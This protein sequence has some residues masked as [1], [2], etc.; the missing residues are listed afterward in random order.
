M[1]KPGAAASG[2]YRPSTLGFLSSFVLRALS[3]FGRPS[4]VIRFCSS[5]LLAAL[6]IHANADTPTSEADKKQNKSSAGDELFSGSEIRKVRIEIPKDGLA[7]LRR[8]HWDRSGA[9]EERA[10]VPVTVKE[11]TTVYTNVALHLKG[12]EGSFRPVD[13]NPAMTLN[14][15]K[16]APGQRFHGLQKISLN[17]S[18]EDP[19]FLTEKICRELF[20]AAGVPVPRADYAEVELNGRRVGLY[21][22][23]E[24][25]NKQFLRRYFKNPNGNLYDSGFIRDINQKLEKNSGPDPQDQSDLK[26]LVAAAN[27]PD[28]TNRLARLEKVLDLDLFITSF[29]MQIMMW[30]WDGYVMNINN[31]RIY[32]DPDSDRLTMMPHGLDQ[33]FWEPTGHILPNRIR[34]MLARSVIQMPECRRRYQERLSQLLT[35][36]F[37]APTITNRVLQQA[38]RIRPVLIERNQHTAK[39]HMHLVAVLCERIAQRAS[40]IAQQLGGPGKAIK[41]DSTGAAR[42]SDWKPKTDYG[43][44]SFAEQAGT[45]HNRWL[46]ISAPN[47]SSVGSWRTK[48]FLEAGLYRLEGKVKTRGVVSDPG[49]PR[50]GVGLRTSNRRLTQKLSGDNDWTA[51]TYEFDLPERADVEFVCELRAAK[52]EAWFDAGSLRLIRK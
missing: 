3:F 15:D 28:L 18:A 33:M 19:T 22:L 39:D 44:P 17:N 4:L 20:A 9:H 1:T 47:G 49:D 36:V 12:A 42:L 32:H 51:V 13:Q 45:D 10:N 43:E 35:N 48:I 34:G 8:Y 25:W 30:N 37:N 41:F 31:Y 11:G 14:F 7:K 2:R 5:S 52:G 24:G 29:A 38:A 23:V 40:S 16:F 50:F 46:H 6:V 21:V 27:E 26:A